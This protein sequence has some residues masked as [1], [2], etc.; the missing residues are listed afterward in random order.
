SDLLVWLPDAEGVAMAAGGLWLSYSR[1]FLR[2]SQ[3]YI[4]L[5]LLLRGLWLVQGALTLPLGFTSM[6]VFAGAAYTLSKLR[7][8][9]AVLVAW[10]VIAAFE[11][12][13]IWGLHTPPDVLRD[14]NFPILLSNIFGLI[15][16]YTMELSARRDFSILRLLEAERQRSE[17]LLLN[18]LPGPIAE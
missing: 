14:Q 15:A 2:F 1:H 17:R 12:R 8:V 7:L 6:I 3:A 16:G 13:S 5:F 11:V 10:T 18:I 4:G 9:S